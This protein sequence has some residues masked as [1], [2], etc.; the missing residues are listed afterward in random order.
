MDLDADA[1]GG[2]AHGQPIVFAKVHIIFFL[3]RGGAAV[4]TPTKSKK[5]TLGAR[6]EGMDLDSAQRLFDTEAFLA[7][8][9]SVVAELYIVAQLS[10]QRRVQWFYHLVPIAAGVALIGAASSDALEWELC[11]FGFAVASTFN[12][13]NTWLLN[14]CSFR[15]YVE[16]TDDLITTLLLPRFSFPLWGIVTQVGYSLIGIAH[17]ALRA[18]AVAAAVRREV[19]A[20]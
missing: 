8:W 2:F 11:A 1:P 5:K 3:V 18:C 4:E 16:V 9:A 19:T 13:Y 7:G 15:Q 12:L 17:V 6:R 14:I 10:S 20:V